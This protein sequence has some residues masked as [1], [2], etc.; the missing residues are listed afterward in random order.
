MALG[1]AGCQPFLVIIAQELVQKVNRL[2]RNV[3]L[4]LR[5]NKP[6]PRFSWV[7]IPTNN[8]LRLAQEV[9]G[10]WH[11]RSKNVIVLGIQF[12]VVL[13]EIGIEFLSAKNLGDLHKLVIVVMSMEEW[14]LPKD[15]ERAWQSAAYHLA[16]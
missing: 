5:G 9:R 11:S 10:R 1:F 6:G 13:L 7:S 12:D 3:P 2:I 16:R 14:F 4:V 8:A 15:L